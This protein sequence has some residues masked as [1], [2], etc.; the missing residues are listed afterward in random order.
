MDPHTGRDALS[1]LRA[2]GD[3]VSS[4]PDTITALQLALR[5]MCETIDCSYGEAWMPDAD[6]DALDLEATWSADSRGSGFA[7]SAGT[8]RLEHGM[9]LPGHVWE[10]RQ[11]VWYPDV[12]ILP[13]E[14]FVRC[15]QAA[16]LGLHAGL[17]VP[18]IVNDDVVAVLA[19]FMPEP[20]DEDWLTAENV[21]LAA[22]Q[23]GIILVRERPEERLQSAVAGLDRAT[24]RVASMRATLDA[25]TARNLFAVLPEVAEEFRGTVAADQVAI[26]V[27][28]YINPDASRVGTAGL[29][30]LFD[31]LGLF[32]ELEPTAEPGRA[33]ANPRILCAQIALNGVAVGAVFAA[34]SDEGAAF[35]PADA[36][37]AGEFADALAM[38]WASA[39]G[40]RTAARSSLVESRLRLLGELQDDVVQNLFALGLGLEAIASGPH[41]ALDLRNSVRDGITR[42]NRLIGETRDYVQALMQ[43]DDASDTSDIA[44]ALASVVNRRV[45]RAVEVSLNIATNGESLQDAAGM[46]LLIA[47]EAVDNAIEHARCSALKVSLEDVT[48]GVRLTITDDGRGFDPQAERQGAGIRAM[49]AAASRLNANLEVR[50]AP[51]DG[52]TVAVTVAA[53]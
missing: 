43:D 15:Q 48:G 51:G 52:T 12:S 31:P 13:P 4:A 38:G 45:P 39:A 46:L 29:D 18:V 9:G 1:L 24:R 19:F 34:R 14:Q 49:R 16:D 3:A 5:A 11:P 44:R 22:A 32:A 37:R 25:A 21:S 40:V 20:R 23:L 2:V 7:A 28:D 26:V 50:S 47:R 8:V 30:S 10:L 53:A 27:R 41:V 17:G 33:R 42:I 6:S 35:S 36:R